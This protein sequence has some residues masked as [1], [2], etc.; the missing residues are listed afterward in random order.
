MNIKWYILYQAKASLIIFFTACKYT[1]LKKYNVR[2]N[3]NYFEIR[4]VV[5]QYF[6]SKWVVF[7]DLLK[8]KRSDYLCVFI[9]WRKT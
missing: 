4:S 6:F 2:E 5:H 8:D 3:A 9:T 7:N 1:E